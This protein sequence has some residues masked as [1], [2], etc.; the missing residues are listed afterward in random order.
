MTKLGSRKLHIC[1]KVTKMGS[2]IGHSIDYNGVG[3]LRGQGHIPTQNK[4]REQGAGK[5]NESSS[6]P[7]SLTTSPLTHTFACH[8]KWIGCSRSITFLVNRTR[9]LFG[10]PVYVGNSA[11]K[12]ELFTY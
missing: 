2:I 1:P 7:T 3:A 10:E 4:T 12:F 6:F 5:E 8:S 11:E 9:S